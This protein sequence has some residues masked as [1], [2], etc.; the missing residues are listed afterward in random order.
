M[1][2]RWLLLPLDAPLFQVR[3]SDSRFQNSAIREIIGDYIIQNPTF[4]FTISPPIAWTWVTPAPVNGAIPA[5]DFYLGQTTSQ[6]DALRIMNN[7][8]NS[9]ILISA[10]KLGYSTIGMTWTVTGYTAEQMWIVDDAK[11]SVAGY[12][13][14]Y[15]PGLGA[16]LQKRGAAI[17]ATTPVT[18]QKTDV[19][20]PMTITVRAPGLYTKSQWQYLADQV[21]NYLSIRE[22]VRFLTEVTVR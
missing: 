14:S 12:E 13:N 2:L 18:Y 7:A 11:A 1:R 15:V 17:G 3:A 8:I 6:A 19:A 10:N 22:K 20:I 21:S 9:A 16:V 4:S 5:K